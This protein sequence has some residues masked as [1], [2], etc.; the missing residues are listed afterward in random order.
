MLQV[1]TVTIGIDPGKYSAVFIV[2]LAIKM[3]HELLI[4][5]FFS[6]DDNVQLFSQSDSS[7]WKVY[8]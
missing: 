6:T 3:K 1:Y 4:G 7:T 8:R 2:A 5:L